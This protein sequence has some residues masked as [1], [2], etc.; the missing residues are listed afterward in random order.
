MEKLSI[1]VPIWQPYPDQAARDY[2]ERKEIEKR[3]KKLAW[4]TAWHVVFIV[5]CLSVCAFFL[6]IV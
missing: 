1:N 5:S 3:Q 6:F 2:L 4:E